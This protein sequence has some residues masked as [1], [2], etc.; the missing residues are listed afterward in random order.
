MPLGRRRLPLDSPWSRQGP[1]FQPRMA[2]LVCTSLS[3]VKNRLAVA[4]RRLRRQVALASD[5]VHG[6]AGAQSCLAWV[7]SKLTI[8]G[9][10]CFQFQ[11]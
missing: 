10:K 2:I 1:S 6:P 8:R 11:T 9:K 4:L 5:W 7:S 3:S